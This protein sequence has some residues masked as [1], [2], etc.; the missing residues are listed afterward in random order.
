M[1]QDSTPTRHLIIAGVTRAGTTSLYN[2][3]G[4]HPE[5]CASTIKETRFFLDS[6]ELRRLHR[7]EDGPELYTKYFLD[8]TDHAVRLEATP[9]YLYCPIAAQRIA[10]T[11]PG[12]HIVIILREPISRLISWRRYAIQNGLLNPDTTLADYIQTQFDADDH[13]GN[14]PL[15]QHM[16]ALREG[17][18]ADYLAPWIESFGRDRLTV[19]H[20]DD[21]LKDP[22]AVTRQLCQ[23]LGMDPAFYDGYDFKV[24]NESRQVRWPKIHAAYRSLIWRIKPHIHDKPATRAVLKKVRRTTDAA[25]GRTGGPATASSAAGAA[26]PCKAGELSPDDRQRL[27]DYYQ[28]EPAALARLLDL[29]DWQW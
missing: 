26:T 8:C 3:L 29:P 14:D 18:Y 27:E 2:Y 28:H 22:A 4:D 15:P 24:H 20:Y 13:P 7:F 25:L 9:D 21:L 10:D 17:R 12:A 16:R 6:R 1:T 19:I 23:S 11:L 5:T